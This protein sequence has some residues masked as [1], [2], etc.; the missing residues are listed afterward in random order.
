MQRSL[1]SVRAEVQT[2]ERFVLNEGSEANGQLDRRFGD[3]LVVVEEEFD[4]FV[5]GKVG[6]D[7]G[8]L[9]LD[10]NGIHYRSWEGK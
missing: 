6:E 9:G 5:G 10:G 8:R 4:G 2:S 7:A 1:N 3:S